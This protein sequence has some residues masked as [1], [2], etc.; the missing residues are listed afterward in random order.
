[1]KTF[2]ATRT[3]LPCN[4][5]LPPLVYHIRRNPEETETR[6][7]LP[8]LPYNFQTIISVQLQEAYRT[9]TAAK[10]QEATIQFRNIIHSILLIAVSKK[11][12]IDEVFTILYENN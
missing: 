4:V 5:S 1:L 9:T 6:R 12:E 10:F 11:S 7:M 3:Y 2:Q 8:V